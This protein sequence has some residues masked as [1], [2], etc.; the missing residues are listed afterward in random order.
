MTDLIKF[1]IPVCPMSLQT[2]GKQMIIRH[3]RP[4]FFKT[5]KASDYQKII[6]LYASKYRP[7]TPWECPIHLQ[8]DYYLERP[9]RLNAK[10]Y[11]TCA[12]YHPKRPDLDNLQKGTQDAFK[13]FWLDDSQIVALTL[14][15]FYA[16]VGSQPW[17]DVK[18]NKLTENN[19]EKK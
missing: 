8:V 2:S 16:S 11:G 18:M 14:R 7:N 17:I 1:I 19:H 6:R 13:G 12:Q 4:I 15:K 5:Q 9:A 3:G 10:K